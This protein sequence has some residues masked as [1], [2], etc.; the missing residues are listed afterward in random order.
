MNSGRKRHLKDLNVLKYLCNYF[1]ITCCIVPADCIPQTSTEEIQMNLGSANASLCGYYK[2]GKFFDTG[3]KA[4]S[5]LRQKIVSQNVQ[6]NVFMN[7]LGW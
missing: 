1:V 5:C 7:V 3:H 2:T 4:C 6:Q